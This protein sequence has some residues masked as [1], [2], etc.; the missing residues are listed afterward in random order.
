MSKPRTIIDAARKRFR[1]YGLAKT[2]MQEIARD[3]GV[4]V[5][6]LYLYFAN[7]D[8]LI[9]ACAEDFVER[10]QRRAAAILA[11]D[12]P[13]DQK[14]R[15]YVLDRFRHAAEAR[16]GSRH[17]AEITRAVLRVKPDRI[18][19]EARMMHGTFTRILRLGIEDRLFRIAEPAED[20]TVFL[21]AIAGFFPSALAEP[22]VSPREEDLLR[23]T[24]WFIGAWKG[25]RK[26]AA[27]A[28][29]VNRRRADL[30]PL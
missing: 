27:G 17:A 5:G 18:E 23:V 2:T 13:A 25:A 19:E 10:H 30:S 29:R 14:L 9:V 21:F 15:S 26:G 1:Y 24:N 28:I 8:E 16:G 3:A 22:P 7:K 4:A 20:A 11:G 12:D 6:T